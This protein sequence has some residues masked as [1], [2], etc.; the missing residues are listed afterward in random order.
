[1]ITQSILESDLV[2]R[3]M[4]KIKPC[5][6]FMDNAE[7]AAAFYT[8]LFP[9]S[10]ITSA[11]KYNAESAAASGQPENSAMSVFFELSGQTFMALNG[12]PAYK[13]TPA[14]SL[15]V[16]CNDEKE[17]DS[18]FA[19][20]ADGG[21]VLMELGEYPFAKKYAWVSDRFGVSWQLI[22]APREQKISPCLMFT[23]D[24]VGKAKQA[25]EFYISLFPDSKIEM[26]HF[27]GPGEP[28]PEGLVA[29]GSF[30]LDGLHFVAMDSAMAHKFEISSAISF[31]IS[32]GSQAEIDRYWSTFSEGGA[33]GQCGWL[34]DK[35]GV[36]WQ[37]IP[38]MLDE[39][40]KT[41]DDEKRHRTMDALLGMTKL[42]IAELR[43]A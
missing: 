27:Y 15:F 35:Y 41:G 31:M 23:G 1:M 3:V 12:G 28:Q 5:L 6:W 22:L 29:H 20:L 42:D 36:A 9:N 40:L 17:I 33:P 16:S 10:K 11:T 39:I 43:N 30:V 24:N 25:M 26:A 8:S 18:L 14:V 4:Q 2:E 21:F 34:N 7:E 19:S 38:S 32:C 37:I 13:H